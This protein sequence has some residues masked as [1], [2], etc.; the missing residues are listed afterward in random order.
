MS[1]TQKHYVPPGARRVQQKKQPDI[2]NMMDF[3]S[4]CVSNNSSNSS[5][6]DNAKAK[7]VFYPEKITFAKK[8]ADMAE[9]AA[10]EKA[11][12]EAALERVRHERAQADARF[13][14]ISLT[15][16]Y[17]RRKRLAQ[18]GTRCWDDIP[19]DY[20]GPDEGYDSEAEREAEAEEIVAEE[21]TDAAAEAE[22]NRSRWH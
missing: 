17:A 19:E 5:N 10:K 8:V 20:D 12:E 15:E 7:V 14:G 11:A 4:L 2:A 22:Y 13:S 1:H 6:S 9:K 3:P 18:I 16:L 21:A